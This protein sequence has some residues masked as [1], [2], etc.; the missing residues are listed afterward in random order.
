MLVAIVAAFSFS[1][2]SVVCYQQKSQNKIEVRFETSHGMLIGTLGA[3]GPAGYFW[4]RPEKSVG[5]IEPQYFEVFP[6]QNES[7]PSFTVRSLKVYPGR[8]PNTHIVVSEHY[9]HAW[10]YTLIYT[11]SEAGIAL[12]EG[13]SQ[14]DPAAVR[15]TIRDG[16]VWGVVYLD[17]WETDRP[18]QY[19][20][21]PD[22]EYRWALLSAYTFDADFKWR[23]SAVPE[24]VPVR[25]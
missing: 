18:L 2:V 14:R 4:L 7:I 19:R 21:H 23:R 9:Q 3:V 5:R 17:Q 12:S 6:E 24:W 22:P 1:P 15:L 16:R 20:D 25:R 11:V 10:N 13:F 8:W